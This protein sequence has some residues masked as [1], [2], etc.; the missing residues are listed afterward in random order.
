MIKAPS[1]G[2]ST[3]KHPKFDRLGPIAL[4]QFVDCQQSHVKAADLRDEASLHLPI[5]QQC[6]VVSPSSAACAGKKSRPEL[7]LSKS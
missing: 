1:I 4:G 2:A 3:L 6:L 5:C 7:D